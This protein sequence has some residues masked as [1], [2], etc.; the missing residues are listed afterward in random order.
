MCSSC[1]PGLGSGRPGWSWLIGDMLEAN[2]RRADR[3]TAVWTARVDAWHG[4]RRARLARRRRRWAAHRPARV[5]VA[6]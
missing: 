1:P 4:P 3:D 2:A 6:R 5:T